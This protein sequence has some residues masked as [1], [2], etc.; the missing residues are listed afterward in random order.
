MNAW[1]EQIF[2]AGQVTKGNIVRRSR[3]SV[4]Q[5]AS[6][7]ELEAEVRRRRFHSIATGDQL[8]IVCNDGDFRVIL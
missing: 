7:R 5:Y 1:I 2:R 8:I 3:R 4:E 6:M